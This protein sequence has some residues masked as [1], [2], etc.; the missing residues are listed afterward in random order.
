[1]EYGAS[2]ASCRATRRLRRLVPDELSSANRA[3]PQDP[4]ISSRL[5]LAALRPR[6]RLKKKRQRASVGPSC[7]Y[8]EQAS[9]QSHFHSQLTPPLPQL[10]YPGAQP[11]LS[12]FPSSQETLLSDRPT[13][14]IAGGTIAVELQPTANTSTQ[15][16]AL[17]IHFQS[18][19]LGCLRG[20]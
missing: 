9:L 12:F 19:H 13:E 8:V 15:R 16:F 5:Q 3:A 4:K 10:P 6:A 11:M 1:M 17:A 14:G 2:P 20:G 7:D 18:N